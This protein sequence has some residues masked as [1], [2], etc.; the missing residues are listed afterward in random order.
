M[1]R[2]EAKTQRSIIKTDINQVIDAKINMHYPHLD[3][4]RIHN[5][6]YSECT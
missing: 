2:Q 6:W 4:S 5:A 3:T 1:N